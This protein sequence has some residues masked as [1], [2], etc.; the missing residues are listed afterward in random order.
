MNFIKPIIAVSLFSIILTGCGGRT[1]APSTDSGTYTITVKYCT[2]Q[3][4]P[5]YE[6]D[7]LVVDEEIV[8]ELDDPV[9]RIENI[10]LTSREVCV[11]SGPENS[12]SIKRKY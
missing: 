3:M 11:I 5:L 12:V 8:G 10:D 1:T 4:T 2:E 6:G 9:V 7:L